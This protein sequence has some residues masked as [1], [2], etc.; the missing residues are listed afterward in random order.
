M[1]FY[2]CVTSPHLDAQVNTH[3]P[4]E[5]SLTELWWG[6]PVVK[7]HVCV[8]TG[9]SDGQSESASTTLGLCLKHR[10]SRSWVVSLLSELKNK[11]YTCSL[12]S[13]YLSSIFLWHMCLWVCLVCMFV[14]V[15]ALMSIKWQR[16]FLIRWFY[17][18]GILQKRKKK[19]T[20]FN[21]VMT[22]CIK[23]RFCRVW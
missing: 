3:T 23:I 20:V 8:C 14:C 2:F 15:H 5:R 19:H 17:L 16:Y 6:P 12:I 22:F 10:S 9:G 7:P 11:V 13:A 18:S 1:C 4:V 21:P